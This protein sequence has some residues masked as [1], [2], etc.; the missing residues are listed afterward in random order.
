MIIAVIFIF[1]LP[2][3][4]PLLLKLFINCKIFKDVEEFKSIVEIFNNIYPIVYILLGIVIL[5]WFFHKW[6]DIKDF[7]SS[8]D[9]DF[10]LK[11]KKLSAKHRVK[12]EL[13]EIDKS[14]EFIQQMNKEDKSIDIDSTQQ[15]IK[16]KLGIIS[17]DS[18]DLLKTKC[19]DC[20]FEELK[21]EISK[22][23]NF[24]TY[25]MIN[26]DTKIL[27]HV[28]YNDNYIETKRFKERIIKGYKR[29]NRRNVKISHKDIND[30]AEKRYQTIYE[31]LKFL[32][33]LEPSED[34]KEIKLTNEGKKF[35]EKYIESEQEG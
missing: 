25:N 26:K 18:E 2:F 24:A 15:E 14:Q 9:Y 35:V 34:D 23:R 21:E 13:A 12:E 30:I 33:I 5:L 16:L 28:I 7:F 11:E 3:M 27:L 6:E 8:M 32:N 20:N 1:I 22:L 4:L 10:D 17:K 19:K 31:G 29:R